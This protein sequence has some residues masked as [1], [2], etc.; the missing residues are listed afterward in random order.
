MRHIA[1]AIADRPMASS[2]CGSWFIPNFYCFDRLTLPEGAVMPEQ[3]ART[4]TAVSRLD[5]TATVSSAKLTGADPPGPDSVA[6]GG[7]GTAYNTAP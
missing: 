1:F 6:H 5:V 2:V 3:D 4:V 7:G